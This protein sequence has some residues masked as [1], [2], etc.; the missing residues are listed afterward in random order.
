MTGH[1]RGEPRASQ[2][3]QVGLVS[4]IRWGRLAAGMLPER[5]TLS[6]PQESSVELFFFLNDG[7]SAFQVGK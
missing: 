6:R 3:G 1:F 7:H 2:E 4:V 5:I